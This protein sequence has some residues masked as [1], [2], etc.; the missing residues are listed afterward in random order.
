MNMD[1]ISLGV[2]RGRQEWN[3]LMSVV[4][5]GGAKYCQR[6]TIVISLLIRFLTKS[7]SELGGNTWHKID[8]SRNAWPSTEHMALTSEYHASCKLIP[9]GAY[10]L[11]PQFSVLLTEVE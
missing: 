10:R 3:L 2:Y 9:R 11:S 4:L 1:I 5:P 7:L 8:S 6:Y